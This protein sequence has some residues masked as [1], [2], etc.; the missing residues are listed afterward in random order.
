MLITFTR[1]IC[2]PET[3]T[4]T[5]QVK[6]CCLGYVFKSCLSSLPDDRFYLPHVISFHAGLYHTR[7]SRGT[8]SID[9]TTIAGPSHY[10]VDMSLSSG[11]HLQEWMNTYL[12]RRALHNIQA[13]PANNQITPVDPI[14]VEA[15]QT[16]EYTAPL[17][18][19]SLPEN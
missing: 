11:Q 19:I 2:D 16:S 1:I 10:A 15:E 9:I 12:R 18:P 17:W 3:E 13:L 8:S 7:K 14:R 6:R 5:V 4:L